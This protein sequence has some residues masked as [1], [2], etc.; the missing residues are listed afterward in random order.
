[1]KLRILPM[2]LAALA[3][4]A[5]GAQAAHETFFFKSVLSADEAGT[6]EPADGLGTFEL[7]GAVGAAS[8][9]Y[10]FTVSEGID[11]TSFGGGGDAIGGDPATGMHIHNA[12]FGSNGP[13]VYNILADADTVVEDVVGGT[14]I[15]GTWD[16]SEGLDAF[17]ADLAAATG[18]TD[19]Y[20][21][22]HTTGYPAGA[23]RGQIEAVASPVP[24]PAAA[25]F[26]AAGLGALGLLRLRRN[27]E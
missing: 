15:T 16:S 12:G 26:L 3:L 25:P 13:V 7:S 19:L 10:Q 22:L 23:I 18:Y 9:W 21:N 1:M 20:V 17:Y 27:K 14:R 6:L 24:I 11:F 8:L 4:S 2:T 5:A